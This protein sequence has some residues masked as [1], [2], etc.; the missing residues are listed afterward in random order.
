MTKIWP[1]RTTGP[2]IPSMFLDKRLEDDKNYGFSIFKPN[3]NACMKWLDD[4][5]KGS[6]VYVSFGSV[7]ALEVE[8]M[9]EIAWGLR[10]SNRCFLWVVRAS[11]EAKLL[12]NF[13]DRG[14]V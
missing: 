12:K 1:L 3:T 9:E 6:V 5:P 10:M 4:Q 14:D 2:T 7:A 13:V 8:Q 11:E